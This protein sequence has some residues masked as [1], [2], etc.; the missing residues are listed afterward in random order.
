SRAGKP[1]GGY[2]P[3]IT[4]AVRRH[5]APGVV[6]DGELVVWQPGRRRTSFVALQRRVTAGRRVLQAAREH[7]THY[8]IFDLL[9]DSD[10][11]LLHAPLAR[12]RHRL[13]L[14]LLDAPGQLVLCPQTTDP[15]VARDWLEG[16]SAAGIEGVVAKRLDGRYQ[17]GRRGWRKLR[18]T[19]T[20]EAIIGG[21]TG[22][23]ADPQLVL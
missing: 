3:E 8:V 14:L 20:T 22:T 13:E 15:H 10:G 23:V 9:A 12:R 17:P 5:F 6:L 21:V 18:V 1:L 2:F 7:P 4:R 16:W 19:S 11:P